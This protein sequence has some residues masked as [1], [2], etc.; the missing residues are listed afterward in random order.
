[1]QSLNHTEV[2]NL[3]LQL[4]AMLIMARAF[5]EVARKNNQPAVV[6]ELFAG[7]ILGPTILG[8]FSPEVFEYMFMSNQG[9][10]IALDGIIQIAVILLLFIAG[11]EVELHLIWSQG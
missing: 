2:I 4:A 1:M 7:I 9:T 10:N 6:G 11:L 3:L 8:T 5:G